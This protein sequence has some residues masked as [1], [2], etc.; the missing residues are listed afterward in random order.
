MILYKFWTIAVSNL[1]SRFNFPVCLFSSK[2]QNV[3]RTKSSTGGGTECHWF[4]NR[5]LTSLFVHEKI[6]L[7]FVQFNLFCAFDPSRALQ[8]RIWLSLIFLP[9][10][11]ISIC[12][13]KNV[14]YVC[15]VQLILCI[16]SIACSVEKQ[17]IKLTY[18]DKVQLTAY[19][20]QIS[21]GA[22]DPEKY[23]DVGYFDVIGNDRR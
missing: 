6:Y 7:V 17:I 22:F 5:I 8:K 21:S 20:K 1:I 15:A 9:H 2:S 18:D 12:P 23:P 19:W 13:W 14:S 3:V 10:F 16:W 11:D 4:S